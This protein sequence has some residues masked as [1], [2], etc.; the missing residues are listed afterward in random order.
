MWL[1]E[2]KAVH[3]SYLR[4][5]VGACEKPP[6]RTRKVYWCP[7]HVKEIC[8]WKSHSWKRGSITC[9]VNNCV[10]RGK[11][12]LTSFSKKVWNHGYLTLPPDYMCRNLQLFSKTH[13]M[14]TPLK[15]ARWMGRMSSLPPCLGGID[16]LA[17]PR[18]LYCFSLTILAGA[19]SWLFL[20]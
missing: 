2:Y 11:A 19:S 8:F 12:T 13:L 5:K 16:L 17:L 3:F 1:G 14:F 20:P 4:T 7:Y 10:V 9:L 18:H 15:Q 6:D